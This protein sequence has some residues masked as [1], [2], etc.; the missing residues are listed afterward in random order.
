[1]KYFTVI[2]TAFMAAVL[3]AA[4]TLA[5]HAQTPN[6]DSA[7]IASAVRGYHTAL[8]AGDAQAVLRLLAPDAVILESGG[9]ESREE[10]R[11]HH[12]QADMQ[13]AQAVPTR[14][15]ELQ[16]TVSGDAAWSHSTSVTQGTFKERPIHLAGAELM[17]LSKTAQGWVIRAIHWSTRPVTSGQ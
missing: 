14:R 13:F 12:L 16:I 6:P 10:Y 2:R 3:V 4:S 1:M 5:L 15:S 11:S 9:R 17:V 7:A 8:E